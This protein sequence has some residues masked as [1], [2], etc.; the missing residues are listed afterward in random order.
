MYLNDWPQRN[1]VLM[2]SSVR[3]VGSLCHSAAR[4]AIIENDNWRMNVLHRLVWSG[5]AS[6]TGVGRAKVTLRPADFLS[7]VFRDGN[8]NLRQSIA[9]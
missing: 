3:F 8:R 4:N 6:V 9:S 7:H 5:L 1:V 2:H